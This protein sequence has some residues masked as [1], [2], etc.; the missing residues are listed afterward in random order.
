MSIA[1][2]FAGTCRVATPTGARP[3]SSIGVGD[4]ITTYD[5]EAGTLGTARVVQV[6][7]FSARQWVT[8]DLDGGR[9][10]ACTPGTGVWDAFDEIFRSAGSLST[11]AELVVVDGTQTSAC[12][13]RDVP[14]RTQPDTEVVHLT[15]ASPADSLVVDGVVVRH[16]DAS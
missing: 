6:H 14:E 16:K 9:L 10:T 2:G 15:L 11:L 13:V 3:L 4:E 7:R 1:L 5:T 12:Q 8:I